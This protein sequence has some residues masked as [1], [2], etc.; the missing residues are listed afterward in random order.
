M[1]H[2]SHPVSSRRLG[3]RPGAR[4]AGWLVRMAVLVLSGSMTAVAAPPDNGSPLK[5]QFTTLSLS[6]CEI[7]KRHADGNSWL[8]PGLPGY[9]VYVAEGD[10]RFFMGFGPQAQKTRASTQTLGAFNTVFKDNRSRFTIEWRYVRRQGRDIPHAAIV[11]FFTSLDKNRGQVLVVTRIAET[12]ACH[13][14][15]IDALANVHSAIALAR[16]IADDKARTFDCKSEPQSYGA[17][18]RSPL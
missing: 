18:G 7:V 6:Q 14:G 5:S 2:W 16:S 15:Y 8:C 12:E 11:R 1:H 13:V 17:T 4:A 9:P 10:L 3:Q